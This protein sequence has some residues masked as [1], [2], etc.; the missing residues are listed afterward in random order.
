MLPQD[1]IQQRTVGNSA[2][3]HGQKSS[4]LSL[5][6]GPPLFPKLSAANLSEGSA[7]QV[8]FVEAMQL[9]AGL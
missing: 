6:R 3:D 1:R 9:V 8:T 7:N 4:A 5:P 2:T